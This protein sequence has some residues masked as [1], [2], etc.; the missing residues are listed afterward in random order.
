MNPAEEWGSPW[1][2]NHRVTLHKEL[3]ANV[4]SD[5]FPGKPPQILL[6][7]RIVSADTATTTVTLNDGS[8][9]KA[10]LIIAA[11]G[12]RSAV[13][14]SVIGDTLVAKP[15]GHSAYRCLIPGEAFRALG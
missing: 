9:I 12:I 11:D 6:G 7:K 1:L 13:Q 5:K 4:T 14:K 3:L 2:L 10:D 8:E 15:S